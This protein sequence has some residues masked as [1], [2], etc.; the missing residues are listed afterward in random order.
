MKYF[1]DTEFNAPGAGQPIELI[2]IAIVAEDGRE[3]YEVNHSLFLFL[4]KENA[5]PFVQEHVLPHIDW[6]LAQPLYIIRQ[7]VREFI[8]AGSTYP[9]FWGYYASYDYVVLSQLMGSMDQWPNGWP[10]YIH[11]LRQSLDERGLQHVHQEGDVAH[12]ALDDARWVRDTYDQFIREN[13][14]APL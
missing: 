4:G 3:L 1:I 9:E 7:Q 6:S 5:T 10:Y 13:D 11:D 14:N 12:I 8:D 2:S